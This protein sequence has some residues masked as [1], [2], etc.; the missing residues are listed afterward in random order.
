MR[1]PHMLLPLVAAMVAL[2]GHAASAQSSSS[3]P[4]CS[5]SLKS[6]GWSCY[7]AS[8]EQCRTTEL[9]LGGTCVPNPA[10]RPIVAA[11]PTA[12]NHVRTEHGHRHR[13]R[14]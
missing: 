2:G 4:W 13:D 11:Q 3:Y 7:F 5:M 12:A 10:Y 14:S 9:G 1:F 6:G 8:Q